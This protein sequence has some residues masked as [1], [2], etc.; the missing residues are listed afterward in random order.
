[1]N[2]PLSRP[3]VPSFT[4]ASAT[5]DHWGLA[6]KACLERLADS[7]AN[8]GVL[9]VTETFN[10]NL[11][12]VLTFL[13]ETTRIAHWVGAVVP[14]V[15]ADGAVI[16]H[17]GGMA[18]MTGLLPEDSFRT[19]WSLDPDEAGDELGSWLHGHAPCLALAHGDPRSPGVPALVRGLAGDD[20][21]VVGGLVSS[22]GPPAQL[23]DTVVSGGI[24]GLLVG[25]GVAAIC[26]VTQGCS[27][28]G[29]VHGVDAAVEGVVM[30]L[31]GR[32]AVDVLKEEA[33]QLIA[34]DLRRAAGYI[35]VA[36]PVA[37]SATGDYL[38]R[39]L[40][41]I[42]TRQGWL[43]VG[44]RVE[45]GAELLFVRRDPQAAQADME[46]MLA[47][48]TRRLAGRPALAAFYQSCIG[49]GRHVFGADET[50][51][52]LIRAALGEDV[53]LIGF[54]GHGEFAGERV[55]AYTGVLTVLAGER[56]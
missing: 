28:I 53:P 30:R 50:E 35:H 8:V 21:C 44:E 34:R 2:R 20:G 27:P 32:P 22:S 25:S 38:V 18:V 23:A 12:S 42:D 56:P 15:I 5:G 26:G 7:P 4:V 6:A 46:R 49:R 33:G 51:I 19:F 52:A 45:D 14:A 41:G 16:A 54:F 10:Q 40:L 31:D 9:Y 3:A 36:L 43:A 55:H 11:S 39:T 24:A 37:G 13:R 17:E 1:M 48:V 47:D 29:R